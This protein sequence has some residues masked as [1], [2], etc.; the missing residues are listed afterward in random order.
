MKTWE[1]GV[2]EITYPYA[3]RWT[4]D[5]VQAEIQREAEDLAG[6]KGYYRN[7]R[8]REIQPMTHA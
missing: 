4:G 1:I 3:I 7:L 6:E 8:V 2:T 5:F